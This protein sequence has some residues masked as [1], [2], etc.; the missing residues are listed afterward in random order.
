MARCKKHKK[1]GVENCSGCLYEKCER[2]KT[3]LAQLIDLLK[4]PALFRRLS[5]AEK[6]SIEIAEQVLKDQSE[7]D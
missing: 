7:W 2:L 4:H 1:Y 6:Y 5:K 3:S